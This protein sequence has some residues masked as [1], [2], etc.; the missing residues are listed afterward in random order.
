MVDHRALSAF[1]GTAVLAVLSGCGGGESLPTSA[2]PATGTPAASFSPTTLVFPAQATGT[3][4][5]ADTVTVTNTGNAALSVNGVGITGTNASAFAS[6]STCSTVAP[7]GTCRISV[8]FSPTATG[9]ATA[10]LEV[11]SNA[12]TSPTAVALSGTGAPPVTVSLSVA[13]IMVAAGQPAMLTWSATNA[14]GCVASNGWNGS[15]ATSGSLSVAS[16]AT[17]A[18]DTYTLTCHGNGE[19]VA[20]SVVLTAYG[21]LTPATATNPLVPTITTSWYEPTLDVPPP[22]YVVR[23]TTHTVVAPID[24]TSTNPNQY[25]NYWIGLD[26]A[27]AN[28][29]AINNG[30]LQPVLTF[31]AP[32]QNWSALSVYDN[33]QNPSG[34]SQI[35]IIEGQQSTYPDQID[36]IN[37]FNSATYFAPNVGDSIAMAITFDSTSQDWTVVTNDTTLR[38]SNTLIVNLSGQQQNYV[39]FALEIDN[40]MPVTYSPVFTKTVITFAQPDISGICSDATGQRNN[41]TMTPPQLDST[42]KVCTIAQIIAPHP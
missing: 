3:T 1:L 14:T 17:P 20:R 22:N 38:E 12:S 26:P 23:A 34:T 15:E 10:S 29:G 4:S 41:Y 8:T 2:P 32:Y 7:N 42:K 27:R 31:Y 30:V 6:T 33:D 25:W 35:P 28:F 5:S 13:P 40:G 9:A 21:P 18:Y 19:S 16:S 37:S 36:G 11:S 24:N 39:Y